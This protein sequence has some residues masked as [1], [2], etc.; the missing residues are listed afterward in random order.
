MDG[1]TGNLTNTLTELGTNQVPLLD[2][3]LPESSKT[4]RNIWFEISGNERSTTTTDFTLGLALDSES[5]V[6]DGNHE[7]AQNGSPWYKFIWV[8]NSMTTSSAHAFKIRTTVTDRMNLANA[9]IYVTYEYNHSTSTS[10]IN[11]LV[12]PLQCQSAPIG[13]TTSGSRTKVFKKFFVQETNISLVQSGIVGTLHHFDN[14]TIGTMNLKCG[15]QA[16]RGYTVEFGTTFAESYVGMHNYMQRIDSGGAQG[17]GITLARG[18]N[19]FT[20][21]TYTT[22]AYA[23]SYNSYCLYLNYTSD[24]MGG[25]ANSHNHSIAQII[26][27]VKR[28]ND[29]GETSSAAFT[30]PETNYYI[31]SIGMEMPTNKSDTDGSHFSVSAELLSGEGGADGYGWNTLSA[32]GGQGSRQAC[33]LVLY[34]DN[35]SRFMRHPADPDTSRMQME[36]SRKYLFSGPVVFMMGARSWITYH[37]QTY[38]IGGYITGYSGGG[39]GIEVRA[40]REDTKEH[41]HTTTSTAG[42]AFSMTWYDNTKNIFCE[43]IQDDSR[44]GR[45]INTKAI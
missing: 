39:S 6:N 45:S 3:F 12:I 28:F 20:L 4:Y 2:T 32:V 36:S 37:T 38:T 41:I 44:K 33:Q 21:E 31:T 27:K 1:A 7:Q 26:T 16:Y 13:R 40:Y 35:S 34:C 11:S 19:T 18:E 42:G 30:I 25:G 10:I 14:D 29:Y 5:E 43:A 15:S 17:A 24:K 8:R 23:A 9:M 22:G